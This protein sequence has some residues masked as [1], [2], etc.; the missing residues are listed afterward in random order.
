MATSSERDREQVLDQ[1]LGYL[2]FS[3]GA[4]DP[5][6]LRNLNLLA[7]MLAQQPQEAPA[8]AD[9][10]AALSGR[11]K[12]LKAT[13]PAFGEADQ[14]SA[15]VETL[16]GRLLSGYL[17]F[18]RDLLF[19]L[20]PRELD[21]PLFIG[22]CC[23]ALLLQGA[24]W[25]DTERIV[26]GAIDYLND[27]IGY[28]PVAT[29]E[30]QKIEPY[31][32]ERLRPLPLYIRDAGVATGRYQRVVT[33]ALELLLETDE[34]IL[35]SSQFDPEL[36]DELAVDPRAYDFDHPA[37]KRP[38]YHFGQWDPHVIDNRGRFRRF[39][40]QQVTLDALMARAQEPGD[41]PVAEVEFEA[42]AVLAGTI[43]MASGISGAGPGAFSST[44]S[45]ADLLPHIA[46]YRD[47]FYERLFSRV[48][49][50]HAARIR[51]EANERRQ[52]FGGA[53]QHL[54]AQL[55]RR[56]ASQLEHVQLA[57]IF[58]RMGFPEAA[59]RQADVVPAASARTLC[60]IDCLLSTGNR[61][62]DKGSIDEAA[63]LAPAVIDLLQRGIASGAIIDPWNIIGFDANFSLFPAVE[64]SVRD[65][66]ADDLVALIEQIFAY[67]SRVWSE[68]AA[69]NR[70]DVCTSMREQFQ[71]TA[72][73]W[74]TYAVHE[75]S[76]VDAV[77]AD[78]AFRAAEHV[79][80]ALNVWHKGG[81]A[82]GDVAFWSQHAG[83]FETPKGY[84]LVIDALLQRGDFVASM[85]LLIHWLGQGVPLEQGESSFHRLAEVW[86]FKLQQLALEEDR[87]ANAQQAW[88]QI[89][90]FLDYLEA[91]AEEYWRAPRFELGP[92]RKKK[93]D[94]PDQ[95]TG[96]NDDE[97][98]LFGAA[99]EDMV[100]RDSTDDG[101]EGPVFEAGASES[102]DELERESRR[103]SRRLNFLSSMA[104]LW[105]MAAVV[106]PALAGRSTNE[107]LRQRESQAMRHW[108]IQAANN[109][110][111]LRELIDDVQSHQV[112]APS[113]DHDSLVEYDRRRSLKE[114]LVDRV[115]STAVDLSDAHRLL[116]AASQAVGEEATAPSELLSNLDRDQQLAIEVF[117]A[118]LRGNT[119]G[120]RSR[121]VELGN[122]LADR[123][124]LYV[125]L[126]KGGDPHEIV[127]A[128]VRQQTVQDLLVWLPRQGLFLET[129]ELIETA[130]EMERDNP[131]GPGAVTEFDEL[132]KIGYKSLVACLVE[133]AS[134][135]N[136]PGGKVP[137]KSLV[138]CLEI[139]TETLLVNWL[140]HSRTLRLSVLERVKDERV[141]TQLVD[142][143]KQYGSELFT[144]R[145][146]NFGNVRAILHQGVDAWIAQIEQFGGPEEEYQFYRDLG[147]ALPRREAIDQLS[148]VLEAIVENYGEYRDYNSTTTQSDRGEL[149][150]MLLDFLRLRMKYDRMSWN[151]R[152]VVWAH[153]ILVC[154]GMNEA[155]R[156]WRRSLAERI[157]VEADKYC[158]RLADLQQKYAMRMPTI[159]DR[160]GERFM[161][162]MSIDR[163]RA[164]V[165]PAMD[166]ARK[167]GKHPRFDLLEHETES[168]TREPSGVGLDVPAWLM[169]LEEEVE[170]VI[171]PEV[172]PRETPDSVIPLASISNEEFHRQIDIWKE[173]R[174]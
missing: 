75:V 34:D 102:D 129:C 78:D 4:S 76:S 85:A 147:G 143:I 25:Y 161:H 107:E 124:L 150:Y 51:Q 59:A 148:L 144:Q 69:R 86:L 162:P 109:D 122:A 127:A 173:E 64:N 149:L 77:D 136:G 68:A 65:H 53:R 49:G 26:A 169:A 63:S 54:N 73:W 33:I 87:L 31:R 103:I 105:R 159:A 44:L 50:A 13:S 139:L 126:S 79:A 5:Q 29:L 153:E 43:L 112:P 7:G 8:W 155:A 134:S 55:A 138:N 88:E 89:R 61:L 83:M 42:G 11:L 168:L 137:Q 3:S 46:S 22:R 146:F 39:I 123:P 21:N 16:I 93:T 32:H 110:R 19:H 152:P 41:L 172:D 132:F 15:M 37:N 163:I 92:I 90:K 160:I 174:S 131:V 71:Q 27:F 24:P 111:Q 98:D 118:L 10:G 166:E 12:E 17:E 128:R 125:P 23:E 157:G 91:N 56:R 82:A 28:R 94:D 2:N 60:G 133:S 58:A 70:T 141:W 1:V 99:Y 81:A 120:V 101:M 45:L 97:H 140:A 84:A 9:V 66:R 119:D 80:S 114:S 47:S 96:E 113:G 165:R 20:P 74:R 170:H 18:H 135:W 116:V 6:F 48:D 117:S 145:F 171:R 38:N 154:R 130:R 72:A 108:A 67:Y 95:A 36:M 14:A 156:L 167:D 115:I 57:K 100:Y 142:F 40:V 121:W 158:K 151:L 104:R 52:P 35:R 106:P 62:L 164:L 30:S